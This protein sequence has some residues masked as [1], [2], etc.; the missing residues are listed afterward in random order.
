MLHGASG[1]WRRMGSWARAGALRIRM[2]CGAAH[3]HGG[4]WAS[5]P[6]GGRICGRRLGG[7]TTPRHGGRAG[8]L[9]APAGAALW[10]VQRSAV[11]PFP[12]PSNLSHQTAGATPKVRRRSGRSYFQEAGEAGRRAHDVASRGPDTALTRSWCSRV[13]QMGKKEKEAEVF[14]SVTDGLKQLYKHKLRPVEEVGPRRRAVGAG[15][16]ACT[17]VGVVTPGPPTRAS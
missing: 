1:A 6:S 17:R 16:H 13:P 9:G 2:V 14:E 10:I 3:P 11:S 8:G 12:Q 15:V 5:W 7:A 4:A